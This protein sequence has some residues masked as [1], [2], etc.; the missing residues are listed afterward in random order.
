[1]FKT[2]EFIKQLEV[3]IISD[4]IFIEALPYI[5]EDGYF[6]ILSDGNFFEFHKKIQTLSKYPHGVGLSLAIMAQVNIAGSILKIASQNGSSIARDLLEKVQS[7]QAIV[8]C[9]ISEKGWK[10][11]LANLKTNLSEK[12]G[13]LFLKGEKSFFTNGK[14]ST[15]FLVLAKNE[16]NENQ[17]V[18]LKES[19]LGIRTFPF[20][21]S[22]AIE[23]THCRMEIREQEIDSD[24]ILPV[25]YS[26]LGE[27]LRMGELLSLCAI[28]CGFVRRVRN[29]LFHILQTKDLVTNE[30]KDKLFEWNLLLEMFESRIER[31]SQEKSES[32]HFSHL[33]FYPFG[34]ELLNRKF[35]EVFGEYFSKEEILLQFPDM[36]LFL[37]DDPLHQFFYSKGQKRFFRVLID[38]IQ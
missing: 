10:G 21:L 29:H 5:V 32:I 30:W 2:I 17:I 20:R 37:W 12:N 14:N 11:K 27:E 33:A 15:H 1:M 25:D 26:Q 8:S 35:L 7:G 13:K 28:F 9:G 36:G 19:L 34:L 3:G 31:I 23:A 24:W 18:V 6:S 38:E 22:F 16:N 4:N